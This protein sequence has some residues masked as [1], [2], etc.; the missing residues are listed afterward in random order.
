MCV[1]GGDKETSPKDGA[2]R[3]AED[4]PPLWGSSLVPF[5]CGESTEVFEEIL[6]FTSQEMKRRAAD[7]SNKEIHGRRSGAHIYTHSHADSL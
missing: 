3:C 4:T 7:C 2:D 6:V 1:T 5:L